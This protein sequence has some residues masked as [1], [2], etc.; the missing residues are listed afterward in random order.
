MKPEDK[1][2]FK[3]I[4]LGKGLLLTSIIGSMGMTFIAVLFLKSQYSIVQKAGVQEEIKDFPATLLKDL[5]SSDSKTSNYAKSAVCKYTQEDKKNFKHFDATKPSFFNKIGGAENYFLRRCDKYPQISIKERKAR[6]DLTENPEVSYLLAV[7]RDRTSPMRF[8]AFRALKK[9]SPSG[10]F[11]QSS[12]TTSYL[13][14]IIGVCLFFGGIIVGVL[15]LVFFLRIRSPYPLSWSGHLLLP[16]EMMAELIALKRRYQTQNLPQ[17]KLNLKITTEVLLL[18]G[19][20]HIK[21]RLQN[22]RLKPEK[23]RN[24]K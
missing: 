24:I 13:L 10:K 17:W 4:W 21:I 3:W 9:L 1:K 8:E 5:V 2:R 23:K 22:I 7:M 14:L 16:E 19:A 11:T 15:G 20:F 18:L 6:K 12:Q